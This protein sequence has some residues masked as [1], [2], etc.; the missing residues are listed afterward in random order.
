MSSF[1]K[2]SLLLRI[3]LALTFLYA[4]VLPYFH[5]LDWISTFPN[6]ITNTLSTTAI[7]SISAL[8]HVIIALWIVSGFRIFI[9]NILLILTLLISFVWSGFSIDMLMN[10]IPSLAAAFALSIMY[11]PHEASRSTTASL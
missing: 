5:I 11:F 3:A 6:F 1:K 8:F 7:L 10:I 2:V 9:P 4:A